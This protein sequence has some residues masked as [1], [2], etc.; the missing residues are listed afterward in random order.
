MTAQ[1]P[2]MSQNH[3]PATHCRR[4]SLLRLFFCLLAAPTA[5]IL[6]ELISAALTGHACFP[7]A[8]PLNS[9]LWKGIRPTLLTI[10]IIAVLIAFTALLMSVQN[11]LRVQG[12]ITE[13]GPR[14]RDAGDG[15]TRFMAKVGILTSSLFLLAVV[16]AIAGIFSFPICW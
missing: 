4:V 1:K 16:V 3:D 5:W 2:P 9:P 6:Q 13:S 14:L 7:G 10:D 12:E 8:V 15:R 11:W